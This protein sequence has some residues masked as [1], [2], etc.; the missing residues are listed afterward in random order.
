MMIYHNHLDSQELNVEKS[1]TVE[2]EVQ[3]TWQI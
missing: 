1:I 3:K 2:E